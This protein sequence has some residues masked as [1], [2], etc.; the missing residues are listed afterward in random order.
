MDLNALFESSREGNLNDEDF[1]QGIRQA[2]T[3]SANIINPNNGGVSPQ[4]QIVL[5]ALNNN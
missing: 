2:Y 5:G 3:V 1:W 4:P